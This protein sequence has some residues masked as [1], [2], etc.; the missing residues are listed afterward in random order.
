MD[1]RVDLLLKND[2]NQKQAWQLLGLKSAHL[3]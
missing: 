3:F 1:G 2:S